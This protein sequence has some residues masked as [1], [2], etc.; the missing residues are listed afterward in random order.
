MGRPYICYCNSC[1]Y[2]IDNHCF[3]SG[4]QYRITEKEDTHQHEDKG[5]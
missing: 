2:N 5:E 1:E 3:I 4:C